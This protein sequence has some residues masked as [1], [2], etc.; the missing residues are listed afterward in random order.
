[1]KILLKYYCFFKKKNT[2]A[3]RFG[4]KYLNKFN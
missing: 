1:M 2:F 4:K 3:T